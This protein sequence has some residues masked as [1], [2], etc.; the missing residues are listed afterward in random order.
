MK[1]LYI[2]KPHAETKDLTPQT[3][4]PNDTFGKIRMYQYSPGSIMLQ[5]R[6]RG[7]TTYSGKGKVRN[8]MSNVTINRAEAEQIIEFL[9]AEIENMG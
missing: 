5:I 4:I 7:A 9:Q 3:D 6:T 8:I 2:T 1:E